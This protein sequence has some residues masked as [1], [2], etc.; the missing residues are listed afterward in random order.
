MDDHDSATNGSVPRA[1]P[2]ATIVV[3]RPPPGLARGNYAW[4]PW[5]IALTGGAVALV[6]TVLFLWRLTRHGKR[7]RNRT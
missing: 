3:E 1:A 6:G 4:P 2:T 5:A 7:W